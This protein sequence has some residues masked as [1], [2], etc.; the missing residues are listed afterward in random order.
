MSSLYHWSLLLLLLLLLKASYYLHFAPLLQRDTT[1]II[2][3]LDWSLLLFV[4]SLSLH[5][6]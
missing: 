4:P 1:Y 6:H 3:S 2:P 5:F